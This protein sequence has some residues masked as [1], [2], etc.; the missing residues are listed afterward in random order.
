MPKTTSAETARRIKGRIEGCK[1]FILLATE[2]AIESKWCNWDLGYGDAKK[3]KG[4][5]AILPLKKKGTSEFAYKGYEYLRI[6][7]AITYYSQGETYKDGSPLSPGYYVRERD[8][9]SNYITPLN[10]W[11]NK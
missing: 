2:G 7:P 10:K 11:L 8:K 5:I 9:D 3:F 4:H 6:Y 1:K